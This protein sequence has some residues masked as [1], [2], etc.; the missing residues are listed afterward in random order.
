[1]TNEPLIKDLPTVATV[2]DEKKDAKFGITYWTLSNGVKIVLKPTDFQADQ[3][4]MFGFSPG[5]MSLIETENAR[6]GMLFDQIVGESGVKN[7]SRID[8]NKTLAGKS[9]N[10]SINVGE[11]FEYLNGS[12][13]PKDF[14]TMLQ[15]AYLKFTKQRFDRSVFDSVIGKQKVLLSGITASPQAYFGEQVF[16]ILSENNP[17]AFDPYD[18][19]NLDKAK[20]EDLQ[21]IYKDR[22]A[23]A[24]DFTFIFVGNLEPETVKPQILKYLGNLPSIK[25]T[26]NWKDWSVKSPAGPLEKIFKRGVDDRS[27]VQIYYL[28]DAVYDRDEERSLAALGELLTIKLVEDLREAK[29]GVY[30]VG[31]SGKLGKIPSGKYAFTIGFSCAPQNVEPLVAETTA[32]INRIQNGE[33][34]ESD[35]NKIKQSRLVRLEE[36]FKNNSYWTTAISDNLREGKEILTLE[37]AKA[38]INAI[39]KDDLQRAAQKYLKLSQRLQFVL[40]PETTAPNPGQTPKRD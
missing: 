21:A 7:L 20:F 30:G 31:A 5:G 8:L 24:S 11:L 38:R 23:D 36:N 26:E 6:S 2:T 33:I 35:I 1:M 12:S 22:F 28:G 13:T 39:N 9:A 32:V 34:D 4:S 27:T 14:E 19:A 18:T 15:L 10:A 16:K 40:M 3:I 29:S 25:R 37:E 17:R